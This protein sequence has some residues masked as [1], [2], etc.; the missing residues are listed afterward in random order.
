MAKKKITKKRKAST[1]K[2]NG[3]TDKFVVSTVWRNEMQWGERKGQIYWTFVL[4][5]GSRIPCYDQAV[6]EAIG[7]DTD[8]KRTAYNPPQ[9]FEFEYNLYKDKTVITG[10]EGVRSKV[11]IKKEY[12]TGNSSGFKGKFPFKK[13]YSQKSPEE[14][15]E[16][17]RM[18]VLG[19]AINF[20][21]KGNLKSLEKTAKIFEGYV[22]TGEFE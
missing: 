17:M 5:D 12:K 18:N 16:I 14:R 15:A 11:E 1:K 8:E 10:F 13:P 2:S 6:V 4:E 9:E 21:G 20:N 7:I 22:K 3:T 19:H